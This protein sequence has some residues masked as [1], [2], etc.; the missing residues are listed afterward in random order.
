MNGHDGKMKSINENDAIS[1]YTCSRS[2]KQIGEWERQ[3]AW[4]DLY[5]IHNKNMNFIIFYCALLV[6]A[7]AQAIKYYKLFSFFLAYFVFVI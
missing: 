1:F 6:Y 7:A 2:E 3:R 4:S 5:C